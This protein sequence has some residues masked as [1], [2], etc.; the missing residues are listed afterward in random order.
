M[1]SLLREETP[2]PIP[3]AASA[4]T[5]S[6]PAIAAARATA[7][8]TTPAP[9]TSTCI[10]LPCSQLDRQPGIVL[11]QRA[12]RG[13]RARHV[14]ELGALALAIEGVVA[15]IEMKQLRHPPGET[16][17]LPHPPQTG[18]RVALEQIAA[19]GAI[20]LRDRVREDPHIRERQIHA[21]GASRRLDVGGIAGEKKPAVLHGLDD[22][23]AHGGDALLQHRAFGEFARAAEAGMQFLPDARVRPV[24]DVVVRRALQIEPRQGRRAHGVKREAALVIGID[25]LVFGR[26][27]FG[28]NSDPAEGI[29]AIIGRERGGRNARPANAVKTVAAADEVAAELFLLAV[30]PEA[31]F[32]RAAAEIVHAHVAR[33]EQNLSAIGK[34]PRDQVLHHLLLAVDGHA[35]ADELA[36][37][38]VVQRAAEGKIDPVVE[39]AFALHARA[40]AGFDQEVARPLLDQAGADAALDIVAAAVFQDDAVHALEVEKMRQHQPGGPGADDTDLRA[41]LVLPVVPPPSRSLV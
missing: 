28:Q 38:D 14:V 32:R 9:T 29:F 10:A 23:A 5:T 19:A 12:F 3:K 33:L 37:I 2:V 17:R 4:T 20:E 21:L 22:E 26:R 27:R 8:P 13:F 30:V 39:H 25:Q 31:N 16:L 15:G 41:H 34:P 6:C 1:T 24:L 35:L 40:D 11:G 18:C 36:E 7:S